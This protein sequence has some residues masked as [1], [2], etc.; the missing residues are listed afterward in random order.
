MSLL[1]SLLRAHVARLEWWQGEEGRRAVLGTTMRETSIGS[2]IPGSVAWGLL[3]VPADVAT[4]WLPRCLCAVVVE[5][6]RYR[7]G[8]VVE[9]WAAYR[10]GERTW[11]WVSGEPKEDR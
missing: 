6:D 5:V 2:A 3:L 10:T 9:V 8:R 4:P 1:L 7:R 11:E